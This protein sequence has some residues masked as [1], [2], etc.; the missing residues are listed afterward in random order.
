M[1][2]KF[3]RLSP[4]ATISRHDT[5]IAITPDIIQTKSR[6][7]KSNSR[8]REMLALQ[9]SSTDPLQRMLNAME[10]GSYARPHRHHSPT[11]AECL[12]LL[13]GSIGFVSFHDD[14]TPNFDSSVLLH[15]TK[16]ALAL[17]CRESIWHTFFSLEPNTVVYESKPG[18]FDPK[19][20][21]ELASWAP[22]ED[23]DE[24]PAYLDWLAAEFQ[25]RVVVR[26]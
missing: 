16:G 3:E 24:A 5:I 9:R 8:K 26:E 19:T 25:K 11:K 12:V 4:F 21:K 6:E 15:R 14:G 17:D 18:P 2:N 13:S 22:A 10:P 1:I 20:D 23:S 7:A